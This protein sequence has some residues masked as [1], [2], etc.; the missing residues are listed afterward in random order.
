MNRTAM[1]LRKRKRMLWSGYCETYDVL[2]HAQFRRCRNKLRGLTRKLRKDHE[3]RLVTDI[4]QNPKAFWHYAN[5]RLRTRCRVE[6][7]LDE[8]GELI[9]SDQEKTEVLSRYFSSVYV[10]EGSEVPPSLSCKFQGSPLTDVDISPQKV[11]AKLASLKVTSSPGPDAIH[12]RVLHEAAGA[13]SR[14]LSLLYHRSLDSGQLPSEWKVGHVVPIYKKGDRRDPANYRPVS[15]TAVPS[16]VLESIIRDQLLLH[17]TEN[18]LLD[19]AQ[20]GFLPKRSCS[21]QMLEVIEDWSAA[22]EEG[23]PVDVIYLDFA[24]A[25]DSVP[26][27]RLLSKLHACGIQGKLL[28]WIKAFLVDRQQRVV[29]QGSHSDW[30]PITSGIPQGSVLGPTLF[31]LFVNDMPQ[32]VESSIKLF[33]DDTKLYS[34]VPVQTDA[35]LQADIISLMKW[36]EEWLLPFN[37][38]KCR[39]MHLGYQ[40]PGRSYNLNGAMLEEVDEE[41]D[42]GITIDSKLKFHQQTASAVSKASQMLAVMRRSFANLDELILPLLFKAMVRPTLEYGNTIW[43]PFSKTEQKQVEQVQS[44]AT[45]MVKSVR[46]LLSVSALHGPVFH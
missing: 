35:P 44:Q 6:D 39:V 2:A 43:G 25:F 24:K 41:R 28:E 16:K 5:S 20:H 40:N 11:E 18:G 15:L 30:A 45:R 17:F 21:S 23:D 42:L 32:H 13:L 4:T 31:T 7:L 33:A 3:T 26:H 37:V 19:P 27:Q 46:R 10:E 8:Q 36:S 22:L 38:T 14:P 29:I 34:R 1:Q 12:P 9:T